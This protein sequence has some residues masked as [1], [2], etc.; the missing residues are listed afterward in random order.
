MALALRPLQDANSTSSRKGS[1]AVRA[2][3]ELWE[4]AIGDGEIAPQV[5]GH[6][7]GWMAGFGGRSGV[8]SLAGFAGAPRPTHR[9]HARPGLRLGGNQ[10]LFLGGPRWF[11]QFGELTN[12]AARRYNLL[13]LFFFQDVAHIDRG[14]LPSGQINVP[15]D[16]YRWPV[17]K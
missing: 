9:G 10:R 2:P 16:G 8:T 5:G 12:P 17:L 6:F 13:F 3:A 14:Y 15:N 4:G 11:P 1:Q 7:I